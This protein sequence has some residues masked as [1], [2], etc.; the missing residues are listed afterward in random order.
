MG[1]A[2]GIIGAFSI[3]LIATYMLVACFVWLLMKITIKRPDSA[4][5]WGV[6]VVLLPVYIQVIGLPDDLLLFSLAFLLLTLMLFFF[7]KVFFL[8]FFFLFFLIGSPLNNECKSY[9]IF[10]N[11]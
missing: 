8:N 9:T 5:A 6:S 4:I 7:F 1:P 3:V 10:I 11:I 2:I